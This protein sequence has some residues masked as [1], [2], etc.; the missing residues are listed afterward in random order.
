MRSSETKLQS[1]LAIE[2]VRAF[3]IFNKINNLIGFK[4]CAI[5]NWSC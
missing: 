3:E 4:M 5:D 1:D 2:I